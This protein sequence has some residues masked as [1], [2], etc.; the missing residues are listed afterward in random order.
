MKIMV[1]LTRVPDPETEIPKVK[2][3]ADGKSL[4][5]TGLKFVV[6]P[7]SENCIEEALRIKESR[8]D[9]ADAFVVTVSGAGA[10]EQLRTALAMGIDRAVH[11]KTT[12]Y[13]DPYAA[14]KL[15]AAVART[16]N[17]D[18]ILTGKQSSDDDYWMFDKYLAE[19]LGI[20]QATVLT[21]VKVAEDGKSATVR[22]EIDGGR[23]FLT[24]Q[25]PAVFS[26]ELQLN[27]PRYASLKGIMS[28]KKKEIREVDPASI[29]GVTPKITIEGYTPAPP[30]APGRVIKGDFPQTVTDLVKA[31]KSEAK[32][33]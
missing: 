12:D 7:F 25:L 26:A 10:T 5:M 19:M 32:V 15:V 21:E 3:G 16:E 11:V 18:I 22:R 33:I 4:N 20:P 14:A 13:L 9:G 17:P 2:I 1:C 29:G 31:L 6:C 24:V 8:K 30:K 27:Q 28:A 23:E